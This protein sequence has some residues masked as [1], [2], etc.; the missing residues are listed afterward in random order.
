[1]EY[2]LLKKHRRATELAVVS[3]MKWLAGELNDDDVAVLNDQQYADVTEV[4]TL[5]NEEDKAGIVVK[6][7]LNRVEQDA[8]E[9]NTFVNILKKK[10]QKFKALITKLET[11]VSSENTLPPIALILGTYVPTLQHVPKGARDCWA[12]VLGSL[13]SSIGANSSDISGWTKLLMLPKC[14]LAHPTSFRSLRWQDILDQVMSRL[15][16]WRDGDFD[17]LWTEAVNGCKATA[18][19]HKK[20]SPNS[21]RSQNINRT[22]RLGKNGQHS[23]ALKALTSEGLAHPSDDILLE[24]LSK[25]PQSAMP[26]LPSAPTPQPVKLEESTIL[27]VVKSFPNGSAGGPSG[28]RPSHLREAMD[29]PSPDCAN[30]ALFSLTGVVNLLAAGNAPSAILPHL[31]GAILLACKKKSGGHRPITVCEVLHKLTSKCLA[32]AAHTSTL[33]RLLPNQ[34]GVGVKRS[35]EAIVHGVSRL[36]SSSS[37]DHCWVLL[38]DFSNAF[39]SL[40]R[41]AM[42]REFRQ[43]VPALSAWMESCYSSQPNLLLGN[44]TIQSCQGVLQGDPLGPLGF[45]LTLQPIVCRIQ[46]EV[47]SLSLNAWCLN[48]G[49]LVGSPADLAAALQIIEEAGPD[50]GLNLNRSKSLLYIPEGT[51]AA[52]SS[53][54]LPP[55]IPIARQGIS[56]LGCPIGAQNF[57]EETFQKRVDKIKPSLSVLRDLE[58]SQ[59]EITLLRSCLTLPKVNITLRA[60]PL[61]HIRNTADRF[62]SAIRGALDGIGARA[63][64]SEYSLKASLPCSKGGL[65]L[66]S[67][68]KRAPAV[69]LGSSLRSQS[70]VEQLVGSS[71]SNSPHIDSSVADIAATADGNLYVSCWSF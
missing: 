56:V 38:L 68:V 6:A 34:L 16:R 22:T 67:V 55:E 33:E 40:N 45:A 46:E 23:K 66:R 27:K 35:R 19:S 58:D 32:F 36:L 18:H 1:M 17:A 12:D 25:H 52:S 24:M 3:D 20:K 57:C 11:S 4:K 37:A 10:P 9:L 61:S 2:A 65:G 14:V 60:C 21:F 41:E 47:P 53:S 62:D 7:L 5:L 39:N 70:L 29:C 71:P 69:F 28:L 48:D 26:P 8:G 50:V 51:D 42:F 13:L 59:L 43:H 31:C 30:R 54:P 49:T 15:T 64:I 63:H 44:H